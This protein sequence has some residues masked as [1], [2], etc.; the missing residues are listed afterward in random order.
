MSRYTVD[1]EE[2]L[3]FAGRLERFA[4][5]ARE[6]ESAI[7][8]QIAELHTPWV[9]VGADAQRQYHE[10]WLRAADEMRR[11]VAELRANAAVAHVN[12]IDAGEIN[13]LMWG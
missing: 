1:P 3:Q 9:G 10:V 5:R 11:A 8:R 12:Y 6:V 4:T 7:D 13:T 2:L